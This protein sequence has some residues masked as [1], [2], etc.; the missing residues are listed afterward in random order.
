MERNVEPEPVGLV[1]VRTVSSNLAILQQGHREPF[2]HKGTASGEEL[3]LALARG[4]SG[5]IQASMVASVLQAVEHWRIRNIHIVIHAVEGKGSLPHP[6]AR[7][8]GPAAG[9]VRLVPTDPPRSHHRPGCQQVGQQVAGVLG[10]RRRLQAIE[11]MVVVTRC[12][13]G[14][15]GFGDHKR[16]ALGH[17]AR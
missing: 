10:L 12:L 4:T 3:G 5:L 1:V 8:W 6:Q 15:E 16:I 14:I 7:R 17:T 13:D 2:A 11:G 9:P